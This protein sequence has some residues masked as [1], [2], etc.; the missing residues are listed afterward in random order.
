MTGLS[1]NVY[2]Y[3]EES[4]KSVSNHVDPYITVG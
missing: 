3:L 2:T 4:Q 1:Y